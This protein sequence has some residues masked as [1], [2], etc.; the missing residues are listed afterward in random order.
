MRNET[1][2]RVGQKARDRRASMVRLPDRFERIFQL[3]YGR[4]DEAATDIRA[5]SEEKYGET[6]A[7]N[8]KTA[9]DT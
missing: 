2:R 5:Q 8:S 4:R 3:D 1:A 7:N 6:I 9:W